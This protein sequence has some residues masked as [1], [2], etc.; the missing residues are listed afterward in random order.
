MIVTGL[1]VDLLAGLH[2][3]FQADLAAIFSEG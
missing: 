1:S 2:K 3:E